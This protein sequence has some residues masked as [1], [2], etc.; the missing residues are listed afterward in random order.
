MKRPMTTEEFFN[1]ISYILEEQGKL[2][3]ILDYGQAAHK[4]IPLK[5]CEFNLKSNLDY[6]GSEGIYL[7]LWIEYFEGD[8]RSMHDL[9]TFKTL[10][11]DDKAMHTMANLLADFILET[12]SYVSRNR[13]D[14]NW[15]GVDVHML[16][17]NGGMVNWGYCCDSMEEALVR[18]DE[19]IEK[20]P[21]VIIR[22]NATRMETHFIRQSVN[23]TDE[24]EGSR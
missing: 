16:D 18:K 17:E 6:G 15:T 10:G 19:L 21:E 7:D 1:T 13:D 3:D 8:E 5:T 14:F 11:D 20:Y 2:P 24:Q 9:G 4:S 23:V 12:Y 22:D